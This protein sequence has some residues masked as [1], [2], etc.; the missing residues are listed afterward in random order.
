MRDLQILSLRAYSSRFSLLYR[1]NRVAYLALKKA[2]HQKA[3]TADWHD[4]PIIAIKTI[5]GCYCWCCYEEN[6]KWAFICQKQTLLTWW[7]DSEVEG[8]NG[9][10]I[11]FGTNFIKATKSLKWLNNRIRK[12]VT[13]PGDFNQGKYVV[14][15]PC[16]SLLNIFLRERICKIH[17]KCWLKIE[18][19]SGNFCLW[20]KIIRR[21][22]T[23]KSWRGKIHIFFALKKLFPI[24][25]ESHLPGFFWS[26]YVAT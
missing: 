24:Q 12:T 7:Q 9:T 21:L 26:F 10:R 5:D 17:M 22:S 20:L 19:P 18:V 1:C 6:K 11:F 8:K 2:I 4:M 23:L 13:P 14:S 15:W 16:E 25:I 3:R